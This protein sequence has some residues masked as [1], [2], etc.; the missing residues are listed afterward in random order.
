[1]PEQKSVEEKLEALQELKARFAEGGGAKRV[2]AQH[3]RGKLTAR[4]R[5]ALLMDPGSFEELDPLV[6]TRGPS[7]NGAA[8]QPE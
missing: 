1:M 5:I 8:P 7:V 6:T 3:S 4:E 2:E